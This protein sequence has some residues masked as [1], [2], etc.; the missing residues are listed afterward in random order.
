MFSLSCSWEERLHTQCSCRKYKQ[1]LYLRIIPFRG[2][3]YHLN[4]F[5]LVCNEM[6]HVGVLL[7][8]LIISLLQNS[9]NYNSCYECQCQLNGAKVRSD[10]WRA[11]QQ[12]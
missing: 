4:H 1:P 11:F 8:S 10:V 6:L 12:P 5:Y 3:F 9:G 7:G 2:G